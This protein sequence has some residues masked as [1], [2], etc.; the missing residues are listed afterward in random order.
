M[1]ELLRASPF[2]KGESERPV[3]L[4]YARDDTSGFQQRL[5]ESP[6]SELEQLI[7]QRKLTK[8]GWDNGCMT[9]EMTRGTVARRCCLES[10]RWWAGVR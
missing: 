2:L 8:C 9:S 1:G 10:L 7:A 6:E 4:A 5:S 3:I